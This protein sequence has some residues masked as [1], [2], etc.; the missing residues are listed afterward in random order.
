MSMTWDGVGGMEGGAATARQLAK[1]G[2]RSEDP[3][4]A[5]KKKAKAS[6][7][8]GRGRPSRDALAAE[9]AAELAKVRS[10][11]KESGENLLTRLDGELV[12]LARYLNGQGLHD[13]KPVL[14]PA[15][16]LSEMTLQARALKVKPH[17]GRVKDLGR[18]EDLLETLASSMPPGT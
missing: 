12:T 5:E 15:E 8:R 3:V 18:I 4:P 16:A 6:S 10:M 7:K 13:E 9:L 1:T 14:P 2:G 11:L 17:K